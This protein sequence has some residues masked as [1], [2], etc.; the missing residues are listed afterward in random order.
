MTQVLRDGTQYTMCVA[1]RVLVILD[2]DAPCRH[3]DAFLIIR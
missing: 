3:E 2:I 1:T